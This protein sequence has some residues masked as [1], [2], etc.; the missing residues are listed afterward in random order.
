LTPREP[1]Q[2][3]HQI[4]DDALKT[5]G[6]I[7]KTYVAINYGVR[8]TKG[9]D[10][11]VYA[12]SVQLRPKKPKVHV[13]GWINVSDFEPEERKYLLSKKFKVCPSDPKPRNVDCNFEVTDRKK[14][15]A[16]YLERKVAPYEL[17]PRPRPARPHET[18]AAKCKRLEQKRAR[19]KAFNDYK[20][21]RKAGDYFERDGHVNV[22]VSLP[23]KGGK[24][25]GTPPIHT[26]FCKSGVRRNVDFYKPYTKQKT[27]ESMVFVLGYYE[28]AFGHTVTGWIADDATAPIEP[29]KS[30]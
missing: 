27:G 17:P 2:E 6:G 1:G 9:S 30:T 24:S 5:R 8:E 18:Q 19:T 21:H 4:Y 16:E 23:G 12:F 10:T 20:K 15:S 11:Y 7:L 29:P 28:T 26:R 25:R 22:L 14:P 3:P 13:S